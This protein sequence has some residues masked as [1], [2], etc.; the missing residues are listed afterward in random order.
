MADA[1]RTRGE[2]AH[3]LRYEDL[4]FKPEETLAELLGYLQLEA[5]PAT[6]ARMLDVGSQAAPNLPGTSF[7]PQALVDQHRTT[8][9]LESSIGRWKQ[10]SDGQ[11]KLYDEVFDEVLS[12][13]GYAESGYVPT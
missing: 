5:S 2:R 12:D 3:L 8:G 4:V 1:W 13:F 9:D 6:I 11:R 7:T 10:E